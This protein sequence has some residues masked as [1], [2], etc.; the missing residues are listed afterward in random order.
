VQIDMMRAAALAAFAVLATLTVAACSVELG[1]DAYDVPDAGPAP[2]ERPGAYVWVCGAPDLIVGS[3]DGGAS[4]E[5]RHRRPDG[6]I[7]TGDLW[8]IAFGDEDHGWAVRRGVGSPTATL[9]ATA[10][11]GRTWTWQRTA[12]ADGR[13]LAVAATD[14]N[15]VWAVGYKAGEGPGPSGRSLV[16]ASSDGGATW[17][18]QRL[19]SRASPFRVAF[20]DAR[21]GWILDGFGD[22]VYA[23]SDGGATWRVSYTAPDG[24]VLRNLAAFGPDRCWAVG[25]R[26]HPQSG[27]V[28]HTTDGGRDWSAQ[29]GVTGERLLGVSFADSS[30]GWVV[31]PEGTVLATSDGGSTWTPQDAGGD[32]DLEQVSFSDR[33]HGW[34]LIGKVALLATVDGG[35]SWSVVRPTDEREVFTG[36]AALRFE[37]A[38]GQ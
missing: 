10:D 32:Y 8:A 4:W 25:Y 9:L 12:P 13:L 5:V 23:T 18:R 30:R 35:Q 7:L 15:H 31:G 2:P 22:R 28:A 21:R 17:Q 36:L 3:A 34:A 26:E 29:E 37:P 6:D 19:P 1:G 38:A 27:Y 11:A 33:E 14:A 16:L 20:T 24:V